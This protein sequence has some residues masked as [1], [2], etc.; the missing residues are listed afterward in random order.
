MFDPVMKFI[1]GSPVPSEYLD[2]IGSLI[3]DVAHA[4]EMFTC[5]ELEAA[6][7]QSV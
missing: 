2:Q 4:E 6:I 1:D 3:R 7:K 5:D